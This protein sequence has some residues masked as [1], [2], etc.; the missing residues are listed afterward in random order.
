LLV[1]LGVSCRQILGIEEAILICPEEPAGCKICSEPDDCGPGTR[2][3]SWACVDALCTPV[4]ATAHTPCSKGFCNDSS[5]SE[6]VTCVE[7][8]D[9][10]GPGGY[11]DLGECFSCFDGV[12]N[13]WEH[14]VDCGGPCK[15]CL[16]DFCT[17]PD[18]CIGDFCADGVCCTS[19]C[20]MP[21]AHCNLLGEA[22]NCTALPKYS[23]DSNPLCSGKYVCDGGGGCGLRPSEICTSAVQCASGRCV[24][25]RCVKLA[26]EPCTLDVE[27]AMMLCVNDVCTM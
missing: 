14:G 8:T 20:D 23:H 4:N 9:C 3:H 24:D 18:D 12:H 7:D 25:N 15:G 21:C 22:G 19:L 13:G 5:P 17:T 11:C 16:G 2:C 1:A 10:P 26:G 27:C 6:C